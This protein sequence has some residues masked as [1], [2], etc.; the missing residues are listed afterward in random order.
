MKGYL[1]A[2]VTSSFPHFIQKLHSDVA[3]ETAKVQRSSSS[4]LN[5]LKSTAY[6]LLD[7]L[8]LMLKQ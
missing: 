5:E 8:I 2:Y 6:S 3:H 4:G 1:Q 7:L